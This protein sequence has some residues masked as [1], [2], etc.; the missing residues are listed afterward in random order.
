MD[1]Q[2]QDNKKE[3]FDEDVGMALIEQQLLNV[4]DATK[5]SGAGFRVINRE[6]F[7]IEYALKIDF[8]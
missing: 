6:G 7:I 4:D 1:I 2:V 5:K 8:W 3:K